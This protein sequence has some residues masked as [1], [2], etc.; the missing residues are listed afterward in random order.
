MFPCFPPIFP[1][2]NLD[3][4]GYFVYSVFCFPFKEMY[5]SMF[6][7]LYIQKFYKL[8][9]TCLMQNMY[10]CCWNYLDWNMRIAHIF[11]AFYL[12][13]LIFFFWRC[14]DRTK[15]NLL[16]STIRACDVLFHNSLGTSLFGLLLK[17]MQ[18]FL[19][20]NMYTDIV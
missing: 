20:R 6:H 16:V 11:Y 17:I 4:H 1:G 8:F 13:S 12:R 18:V 9:S 19:L 7:R 15:K 2:F 5:F 3:I 14:L 10:L